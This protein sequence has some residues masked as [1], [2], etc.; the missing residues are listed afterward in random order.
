MLTAFTDELGITEE[1]AL[2]LERASEVECERELACSLF[3][4]FIV[5]VCFHNSILIMLSTINL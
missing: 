4:L 3:Y 2:K 1:Q 5:T